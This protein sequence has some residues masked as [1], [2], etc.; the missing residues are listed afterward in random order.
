MAYVEVQ[1]G[2]VEVVVYGGTRMIPFH[3]L[4]SS[5]N[6]LW[7]KMQSLQAKKGFT[8]AEVWKGSAKMFLENCWLSSLSIL[9]FNLHMFHAL[10]HLG[11]CF[12]YSLIITSLNGYTEATI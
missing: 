1:V 5:Q 10:K 7:N 6:N 8:I 3:A 4:D 12:N 11:K 2:W 9:M